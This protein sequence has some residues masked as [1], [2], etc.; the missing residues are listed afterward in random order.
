MASVFISSN[1]S[2]PLSIVSSFAVALPFV[3]SLLPQFIQSLL[4]L[5]LTPFVLLFHPYF[6]INSNFTG[7]FRVPYNLLYLFFFVLIF[8]LTIAFVYTFYGHISINLYETY[9]L[10]DVLSYF[11]CGYLMFLGYSLS[12]SSLFYKS[13]ALWSIFLS[14]LISL[15]FGLYQ[16]FV[17]QSRPHGLTYEPRFFAAAI[18]IFCFYIFYVR[19][20]SLYSLMAIL[21]SFILLIFL[22]WRSSSTYNLISIPLLALFRLSPKA[23]FI[24]LR[25]RLF[26]L[27]VSRTSVFLIF[28][29]FALIFF[30]FFSNLSFYQ[31]ANIRLNYQLLLSDIFTTIHNPSSFSD[32]LLGTGSYLD[33]Q[34]KLPI[35]I[36]INHPLAFFVGTGFPFILTS[37]FPFVSDAAGWMTNESTIFASFNLLQYAL[38][39]G[40]PLTLFLVIIS[41]IVIRRNFLYCGL[42][43]MGT[44]SPD[45]SLQI[46]FLAIFILGFFIYG[47]ASSP[48]YIA[49][50]WCIHR[51][52]I[53][54][55]IT[56][57]VDFPG[58]SC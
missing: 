28:F 54:S 46:L 21:F 40:V 34:I 47:S 27:K 7:G 57:N 16:I 30:I 14:F 19:Y 22:L 32:L 9:L 25:R 49:A 58:P 38:D 45:Q 2:R 3:G 23:I 18:L 37:F 29:S 12:S 50:G 42:I 10:K 53:P 26:S 36:C 5:L 17:D 13:L 33:D 20:S 6:L 41:I 31:L 35:L 52:L 24:H 43:R 39:L 4:P 48:Y 11:M 1:Y 55:S 15:G 8:R 56:S 44:R 51:S